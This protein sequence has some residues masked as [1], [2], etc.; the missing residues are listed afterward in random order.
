M[1]GWSRSSDIGIQEK[2]DTNVYIK[3]A[4]YWYKLTAI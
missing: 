4:R 2:S 3:Q 1:Y